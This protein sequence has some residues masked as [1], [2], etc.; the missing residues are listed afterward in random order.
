MKRSIIVSILL[1]SGVACCKSQGC[2]AM[3]NLPGFG[4]FSQLGYGQST[5]KWF[6]DVDNRYFDA[7]KFL[8]G[9]T[10]ITA[11]P[12]ITGV[13][14]YEY[15]LNFGLTRLLNNGWSISLDMPISSNSTFGELEHA[16][17]DAHTTQAYGLG[18]IRFTVYKWLLKDDVS[19]RGNIQF[20]LGL[21]FPT[22]NYQ[23]EDYFYEDPNNKAAA[24]LAPVNV[25]IQ[26]GDGGTGII[27]QMNAYY[28]FNKTIN[29]Y[30]NFFYLI[31]PKDVNG[32]ASWPPGLLPDAV[33]AVYHQAT[34]DVNSV[35]DN[36]TLRAGANF[37]FGKFVA[38]AGLRYEGAPAHD[39]IGRDDGLRRVGNIFSAEPGIHY[40][41]KK[42]F[43]Y[44][45]VTIPIERRT[46]LT[47]P[48]GRIAAI[49]GQPE[50]I[51]PGHF[52]NSIV[53]FG[54]AFTF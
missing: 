1:I 52:A 22:G 13:T 14:L 5:D 24:T 53:Y 31:S 2:V 19:R 40:K 30:G 37:L 43:L 7:Y 21:K 6:L 54:Y 32:V 44:A 42:S 27:T 49:T 33:L 20:G 38:T 29:V 45:F 3:R 28:F 8:T 51:T 4:Q 46:I 9:T 26:L 48:D 41:F 25:A 34:Y 18:D 35:P 10:D 17:G 50:T 36:Y 39:L 23:A 11:K 12:Q 47:V 15:T 16:S